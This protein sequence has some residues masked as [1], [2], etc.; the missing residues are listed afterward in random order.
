VIR[1]AM[2]GKALVALGRV[3]LAKRERVIALEPHSNGFIGTTLRYA[4]EAREASD[5]FAGIP[6]L[7]PAPELLRLATQI[8]ESKLQRFDPSGFRDHYE[9]ALLA[10]L[11]ASEAGI[12][13]QPKQNWTMPRRAINLIDALR[14]SLAEDKP[15]ARRPAP[16][17][18]RA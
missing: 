3:M 8:V 13:P 7:T 2:R 6:E 17:R 1:E 18:K 5:Y 10:H 11:K 16:A 9:E 12:A 4:D 14:R 15:A